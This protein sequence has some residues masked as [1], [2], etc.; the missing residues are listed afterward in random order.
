VRDLLRRTPPILIVLGLCTLLGFSYSMYQLLGSFS[1]SEQ[2][3]EY[4]RMPPAAFALPQAELLV[5][6]QMLNVKRLPDSAY[7]EIEAAARRISVAVGKGKANAGVLRRAGM[8][9]RATRRGETTL[10][11]AA[12]ALEG[13][14]VELEEPIMVEPLTE[15]SA[16]ARS[17]F[18][19]Q[20]QSL[21][22]SS[23]TLAMDFAERGGAWK[24]QAIRIE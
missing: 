5:N 2:S 20:S 10:R 12:D 19:I 3:P 24:L 9:E 14:N 13:R 8:G 21:G 23:V 22:S 11:A 6:P 4:E 16:M 1:R 7:E 17:S 18:S 15:S